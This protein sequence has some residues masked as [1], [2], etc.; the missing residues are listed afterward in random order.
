MASTLGSADE[1]TVAF[2]IIVVGGGTAGCALASRLSQFRPTLSIALIERGPDET[3]HHQVVNPQAAPLLPQTNLVVDYK[4]SSQT[5]L[6]DRN[7]SNF[8]GRLLSGSSAANYGAWM[9]APASDYDLW[10]QHVGDPQ[11][12]YQNL[13]PYFRRTEHHYDIQGDKKQHGFEGPIHT[14]SRGVYPLREAVHQIFTK[15]G[16]RDIPDTSAGAGVAPWV[17]NWRDGNRQHS[18]KVFGLSS[19]QVITNA[20]VT[21]I[22]LNGDKVATGVKLADGRHLRAKKEVIISCGAH[23]TPQLLMLSGIGPAEELRKNRIELLVN[24][25]AVGSNHFDHL[26]LHQ[27]WKLRHPERGLAAGS[28]AFNRPEYGQG[29]PVEWIATYSVPSSAL[30]KSL[31]IA[32]SDQVSLLSS[33]SHVFPDRTHLGLLIAYAPINVNEDYDVPLD[34]SHVSS[35]VLLFQPTSRGSITLT[36]DNP[37]AEPVVNPQYYST[38]ADK[39]MLRSGVRRVAELMESSAGREILEHET[40]PR[41]MPALTSSASDEDIDARARAYS[42]VWHH[43]GGTTA[44]GK[45]ILTSV[46]DSQF[47]VHGVQGLRVVDAGAL[48]APISAT[49]QATVYAMAEVAADLISKSVS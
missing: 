15:S 49:P 9:R 1:S 41:G 40:P 19:V 7:V 35:G 16:F 12:N 6:D 36:S 34:G 23:K 38:L 27:A 46:V 42:E 25:P 24:S 39:E 4:T 29:F 21:Q 17:E 26:S 20:L 2:D 32:A 31:S 14:T 22:V 30:S 44:M 28:P 37:I 11:W 5:Q 8:A 45:D 47:R 10:A 3:E 13:L 48:P 33:Q 43:S 18:S